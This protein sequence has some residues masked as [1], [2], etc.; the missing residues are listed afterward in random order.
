MEFGWC[1]TGYP[2]GNRVAPAD[3]V[4]LMHDNTVVSTP[5]W[6]IYQASKQL[7]ISCITYLVV[8]YSIMHYYCHTVVQ[9]ISWCI[10]HATW[11]LK[12]LRICCDALL[13][14]ENHCA[15]VVMHYTNTYSI[16]TPIFRDALLQLVQPENHCMFIVM[17]YS[18]TYSHRW[19]DAEFGS[20]H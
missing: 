9:P 13:Q 6:C 14:L 12:P 7:S 20:L 1:T 2:R 11:N 8:C 5:Q 19:K 17:H 18:N 15:C 10:T 4:D 16:I 3:T